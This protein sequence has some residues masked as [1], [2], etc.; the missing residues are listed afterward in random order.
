MALAGRTPSR[1]RFG[2]TRRGVWVL[3]QLSLGAGASPLSRPHH[4]CLLMRPSVPSALT[5]TLTVVWGMG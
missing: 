4:S 2:S 3:L 1:T 5:L